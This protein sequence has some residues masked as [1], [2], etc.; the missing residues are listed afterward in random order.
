MARGPLLDKV[1]SLSR[2]HIKILR[3]LT[4]KLGLTFEN[5]VTHNKPDISSFVVFLV[6]RL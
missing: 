6:R 4:C 5:P 2:F 1:L 3:Y